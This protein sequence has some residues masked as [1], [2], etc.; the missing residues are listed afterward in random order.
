VELLLVIILIGIISVAAVPNLGRSYRHLEVEETSRQIAAL[1][2][3]GRERAILDEMRYALY[4]DRNRNEAWLC[5][6]ERGED[7][8]T[9]FRA[10]GSSESRRS[11]PQTVSL[12]EVAP[13]YGREKLMVARFGPDGRADAVQL[14][15]ANL[16]GERCTVVI[17]P[18]R[19]SSVVT[20]SGRSE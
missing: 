3:Y 13:D 15:F 4:L 18:V 19:L 17:S 7:G 11:W 6:E 2:Q 10:L 5:R 9:R 1:A 14:V 20:P 12:A 8:I 16:E